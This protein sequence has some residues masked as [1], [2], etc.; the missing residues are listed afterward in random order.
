MR[1]SVNEND[2][3]ETV[4]TE[5]TENPILADTKYYLVG[6]GFKNEENAEKFIVRLKEREIE[7]FMLGQKG[8]LY[9]VGIASF[10]TEN[11]AYNSLNEL[12]K[13]YPDWNL[14]VYEK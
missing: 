1:D 14:W 10:Y 2:T 7:G 11:E 9:L 8:S 13:K 12:V 3:V 6:G 4:K 5:T